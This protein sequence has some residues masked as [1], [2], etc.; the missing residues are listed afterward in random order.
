MSTVESDHPSLHVER[1]DNVVVVTI[2]DGRANALPTDLSNAL[3]ETVDLAEQEAS[4]AALVLVG[5]AGR[6]SAGFDL[7]VFQSGDLDAV[8]EMVATGGRLVARLYGSGL[9]V[10]AA[11][12]G[13]AVAAGALLLL[14]CDRR[15]GPDAD[16]RIGLNEVAIGLQL[17]DWALAIAQERLSRRHLQAAVATARL[18]DG[19]GA[20]DAGF[21]DVVVSPDDVV[22]VA[23]AEAAALGELDRTAY[24]GTIAVLR[25]PTLTRMG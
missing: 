21:L 8:N 4:V 9:P 24:A 16:V 17:P 20:V 7:S 25:G 1:R 23:V 12:T 19:K 22:E 3:I 14:G 15:I 10:V 2:D 5:R 6:F 13:H 11:C 18:Y